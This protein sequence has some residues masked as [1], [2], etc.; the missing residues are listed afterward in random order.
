MPNFALLSSLLLLGLT[1]RV[2]SDVVSQDFVIAN[3]DV[4]PDGYT[5]S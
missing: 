2:L 1:E 3:T 5:R 4:S